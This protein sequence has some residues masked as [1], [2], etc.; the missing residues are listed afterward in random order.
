MEHRYLNFNVSARTARL[1]GRENFANAEGAIIE[2]VKNTYDADSRM[3]FVVFDVREDKQASSIF[4]IDHGEGM[5]EDVILKHWMTIGTDDKLNNA[6]SK[7]GRVKSGA[8]GI[9]RFALDRLGKKAEMITFSEKTEQGLLWTIDWADFEKEG[10]TLA[11]INASLD[12][13]D[14]V[15]LGE[16]VEGFGLNHFDV[17]SNLFS[18]D[19][20][21]TVI[22]I[23]DLNDDWDENQLRNL[24]TNL[25]NLFPPHLSSDFEIYLY[26]FADPELFGKVKSA[27]YDDFDYRVEA[28]YPADG[29]VIKVKLWRNELNVSLLESEYKE[30]F[31]FDTMKSFP[32]RL[33]DF[34]SNPVTIDVPI[35]SL[36]EDERLKRL[37]SFRFMF[38]FVK[39]TANDDGESHSDK[40]YPYNSVD[41]AYRKK[42][43][44]KF[45][46]IKIYRDNFRVRPYGEDGNDWLGLGERQGR[47]PGGPGQK[48]GYRVRPNQISGSVFISRLQNAVFEDKSSR[49]GI[50]E[51]EDFALFKNLLLTIIGAFETDRNTIMYNLNLLYKKNHPIDGKAKEISDRVNEEA[52]NKGNG[53]NGTSEPTNEEVLAAGYSSLESELS[54][55]EN[56][57]RLLRGLASSGIAIASF[58]H[59]LKSL[60]N[61]LLPRTEILV[62]LLKEY[63]SSDQ[64]RE[65]DKYDNPYY[66]IELIREE[67]NKLHQWLN[68][69]LNTVK[70]DKRE[71]HNIVIS[72]YFTRFE[73]TWKEALKGKSIKIHLDGDA[74][75]QDCVR[76]FEMDLD[77]IFNNFVTNSVASLLRTPRND[78]QI[79]IS[80]KSD[81]GYMVIDFEDN[82]MGLAEEY[83]AKPEV[84]FNAFETSTVNKDGEKTGT[85][86]GLFIVKGIIDGYKDSSINITKIDNGFGLRVIF[87]CSNY[88]EKQ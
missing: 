57:I 22:R 12:P 2:L 18:N 43:L 56:E 58:T 59:E 46:G 52:K 45:Q 4:I 83:K 70:K 85:G 75:L 31:G 84:I 25:E 30:V 28:F 6:F 26:S 53:K 71:R 13:I 33:E 39:N 82:G 27:N 67:D 44:K 35:S 8:K 73:Q 63:I 69:T 29:H 86:M 51:N 66:H 79:T 55:K 72:D 1:I 11:D 5:T 7:N 42:W 14:Y 61:R 77:S 38:Y 88:G 32:Y 54:D 3:C 24:N 17:L 21:G 74:R 78:K 65:V 41:S 16:K 9:G 64:L 50:Q 48:G 19:Y 36:I 87:K 40:K 81:H 80:W 20:K 34:K 15:G 37:G 23:S 49:E 10:Y 76:G 68:Y 62:E 60:S 47:S